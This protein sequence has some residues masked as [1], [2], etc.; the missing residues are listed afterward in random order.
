M[1]L[2]SMLPSTF[3]FPCPHEDP[4]PVHEGEYLTMHQTSTDRGY[5]P[6]IAGTVSAHPAGQH[7]QSFDDRPNRQI[8]NLLESRSYP[9]FIALSKKNEVEPQCFYHKEMAWIGIGSVHGANNALSKLSSDRN[10]DKSRLWVQ[11]QPAPNP[12][13]VPTF[14][15]H[16]G[17][18]CCHARDTS[19]DDT[20][21]LRPLTHTPKLFSLPAVTH[22]SSVSTN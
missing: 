22:S 20:V 3:S 13:V 15:A 6:G 8:A 11:V 18:G 10:A 7:R 14:A 21:S 4:P 12:A 9:V 1:F 16:L 17:G 5:L 2:C 19:W